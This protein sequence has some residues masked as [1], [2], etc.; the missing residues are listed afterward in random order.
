MECY[1]CG[2]IIDNVVMGGTTTRLHDREYHVC[3]WCNMCLEDKMKEEG[4]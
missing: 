2:T 1:I 4:K 3:Q